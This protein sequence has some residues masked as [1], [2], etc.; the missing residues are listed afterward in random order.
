MAN[1]YFKLAADQGNRAAMKDLAANVELDHFKELFGN[2]STA[3]RQP[4]P[5]FD[6]DPHEW[7][8]SKLK[9]FLKHRG[10]ML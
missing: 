6:D 3:C 8:V 2:L 7:S 5:E 4:L 9:K 10:A 1:R